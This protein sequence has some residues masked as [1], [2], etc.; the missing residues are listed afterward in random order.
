MTAKIGLISAALLALSLGLPTNLPAF[1]ELPP[2]RNVLWVK[3]SE[4]PRSV[5]KIALIAG[6]T[7]P[8]GDIPITR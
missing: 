1:Q 5:H 8:A 4:P 7:E 2:G 6:N 3:L